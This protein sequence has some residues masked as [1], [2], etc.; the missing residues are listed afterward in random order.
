MSSPRPP[1]IITGASSG[2]GAATARRLAAS[3]YPLA[4]GARRLDRLEKLAAELNETGARVEPIAVDVTDPASV[5]A[6]GA[7]V[8]ERLGEPGVL[9]S[10]AGHIATGA[11]FQVDAADFDHEVAV[12]LM[13]AQR[14]VREFLPAMMAARGGTVVFVSS[15]TAL[16]AR[17][18]AAA[19]SA[20]KW[21]LEGMVQALQLELEGTGVRACV[22]R[23]GQVS[24]EAGSDWDADGGAEA[25]ESWV[26]VG[27]AR[28]HACLQPEAIADAIGYVVNAPPG[29]HVS[30][31]NVDPL[32]PVQEG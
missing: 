25:I 24:T 8:R 22:V 9:V 11:S 28:H 14:L 6:F 12:N 17:P 20:G 15:D 10:N 2:I 16:R 7:Q 5:A 26:R 32:A 21:G 18:Y 4:I 29:V 19:Y 27:I 3:G 23:P 31:I 1:A 13:G 30:A